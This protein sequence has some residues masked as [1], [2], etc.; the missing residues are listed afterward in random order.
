MMNVNEIMLT[1]VL[2]SD[3][4]SDHTTGG[5]TFY[6]TSIHVDSR[7]VA[8]G[9]EAPFDEVPLMVSS[10]ALSPFRGRVPQSGDLVQAIG[11]LR[12]A[13][14]LTDDGDTRRREM[15]IL[16]T[17]LLPVPDGTPHSNTVTVSGKVTRIARYRS[18]YTEEGRVSESS[19]LSIAVPFGIG[20]R[21]TFITIL[22]NGR[23]ARATRYYVL[24]DT[25]KIE[26]HIRLTDRVITSAETGESHPL[27]VG[28]IVAQGMEVLEYAP[29]DA[30]TSTDT[31]ESSGDTSPVVDPDA[32][33]EDMDVRTSADPEAATF[34]AAEDILGPDAVV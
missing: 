23:V 25:L 24:G 6:R 1:G 22:S 10:Y 34:A 11:E 7:R 16:I 14:Y 20:P 9:E 4:V 17:E 28:Y 30:D 12:L 8:E 29:D 19:S 5:D 33:L 18:G 31:E 3:L 32:G 21:T 26:G 13:V 2:V 27:R 15:Y